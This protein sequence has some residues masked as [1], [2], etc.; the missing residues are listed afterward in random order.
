MDQILVADVLVNLLG[1]AGLATGAYSMK[2]SDP[3]GGLTRRV[4]FA[5]RFGA[6]LFL[7]R[8]LSWATGSDLLDRLVAA[9]ASM[10]PLLAVTLAEGVLR[11][12]APRW[13]KVAAATSAIVFPVLH[14][15]GMLPDAIASILLMVEVV[16]GLAA[17]SQLLLTRDQASLTASENGTAKRIALTTAI[18]TCLAV[19]DFRSILPD[20]PLRLGAL[21]ALVLLYASLSPDGLSSPGRMRS[22]T[23][24]LW[25]VIALALATG[26]VAV[27]ATPDLG[28]LIRVFGVALS[29]MILASL[30]SEY[31]AVAHRRNQ[32]ESRIILAGDPQ[33]FEEALRA[34]PTLSGAKILEGE[35]V[36]DVA[37]PV[38]LSLMTRKPLLRL[39][40]APWGLESTDPG[41]ERANSILAAHEGS[42]LALLS[43]DPLR[44][45][46][47]CVP[48]V[49]YG[50]AVEGDIEVLA[51]IGRMIHSGGRP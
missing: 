14:L 11:R 9:M 50:P 44:V 23:L 25:S 17:A 18:M 3:H 31:L 8:S 46:V 5:L 48:S 45:L 19:T 36:R 27:E 47:L 1:A 21:G 4:G 7:M 12:H 42:H 13:L 10:V 28:S 22:L 40:A 43:K 38:F 34:H 16:A 32:G 39:S 30:V 15:S 51:K 6:A 33:E 49:S 20:I 37:D 26:F 29:A 2:R 24:S 41:V 35:A